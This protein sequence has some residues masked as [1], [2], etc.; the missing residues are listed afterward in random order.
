MKAKSVKYPIA[1]K[2][3]VEE[4]P[5]APYNVIYF[6]PCLLIKAIEQ[7][8]ESQYQIIKREGTIDFNEGNILETQS[9]P[10]DIA[11]LIPEKGHK[12]E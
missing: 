8:D 12:N 1:I 11:I 5:K 6:L 3:S 9:P 7:K 10:Y 2:K 4:M